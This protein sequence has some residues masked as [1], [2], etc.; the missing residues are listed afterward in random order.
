[1]HLSAKTGNGL[2]SLRSTIKA[3]KTYAFIGSSGV[4]KSTLI[5]KLIGDDI[6]KTN[7]VRGKDSKGRHTT[8]RRELIVLDEGGLLIDTPGMRELQLWDSNQ[9]LE[10]TFSDFTQIAENCHFSDCTHTGEKN[11][12][13][14]TAVESGDIPTEH[15]ENYIKLQKEAAFLEARQNDKSYYIRKKKWKKIHKAMKKFNKDRKK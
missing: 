14:L 9:G 13:V 12:A 4:G 6:L 7:K 3:G 5:N 10:D 2:K 15:Y 1:M 8:S 11:C